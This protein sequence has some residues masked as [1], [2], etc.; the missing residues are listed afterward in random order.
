MGKRAPKISAWSSATIG[1][2][3]NEI[4]AV[5]FEDQPGVVPAQVTDAWDTLRAALGQ[6]APANLAAGRSMASALIN[7]V[8]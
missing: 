1:P 2:F 3:G 6:S 7:L 5:S 4:L 8:R